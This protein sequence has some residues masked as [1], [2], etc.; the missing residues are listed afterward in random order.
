[1]SNLVC[2]NHSW[3]KEAPG[4]SL[5]TGGTRRLSCV[6]QSGANTP[7][8]I[9]EPFDDAFKCLYSLILESTMMS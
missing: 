4:L 7:V 5:S 6:D 8:L 9:K 2:R 1:M 3:M